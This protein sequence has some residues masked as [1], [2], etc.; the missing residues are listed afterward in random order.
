MLFTVFFRVTSPVRRT[1]NWGLSGAFADDLSK[2]ESRTLT[3]RWCNTNDAMAADRPVRMTDG[4]GSDSVMRRSVNL[5]T[6]T[7]RRGAFFAPHLQ[8]FTA[9]YC[10]RSRSDLC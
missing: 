1:S 8:F 2:L 10:Y 3:V 5:L 9:V 6:M 4:E 7:I